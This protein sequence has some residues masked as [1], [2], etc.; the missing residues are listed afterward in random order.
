MKY[1][2]LTFLFILIIGCSSPVKIVKFQTT[3][4]TIREN[5]KTYLEWEVLNAD[6]III[7]QLGSDE[8][9]LEN[10][11]L[12]SKMIITPSFSTEYVLNAYKGDEYEKQKC[13]LDVISKPENIKTIRDTVV[14]VK[15]TISAD[16]SQNK[17]KYLNGLQTIENLNKKSKVQFEIFLVDRTNFPKEVKLYLTVKDENGNFIANMAPPFGSKNS[18]NKYFKNLQ[19]EIDGTPYNIEDY[20]IE[21]RHDTLSQKYSFSLVLDHSGSMGTNIDTL[22]KAVKLFVNKMEKQDKASI[23]KFDQFVVNSVSLTDDKSLLLDN[24]HYN[25]LQGFGGGTA[26]I[27][28]ADEGIRTLTDNKTTNIVIL[29][30]DGFENAYL[31]STII[32]KTGYAF[33]PNS[34][35]Y[36]AR[37]ANVKLVTVGYGNVDK[38]LLEKL[39]TLTDG[40]SYYAQNG[41]ELDQIFNELPRLFHNYYVLKFKPKKID[42]KHSFS[43]TVANPDGSEDKITKS[44]YV[45]KVDLKDLDFMARQC[46]AFF[47]LKSDEL[48]DIYRTY[49]E[50]FAKYLQMNTKSTLEIH[51]HTDLTGSKEQ[52]M[53]ISKRRCERVASEFKKNGVDKS[54]IK[55]NPH[56]MNEPVWFPELDVYQSEQNRR[57]EL[58]IKD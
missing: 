40:K 38:D 8:E 28:A 33:K 19:D 52:N 5:E 2:N 3:Y 11:P 7:K 6:S 24:Y 37:A 12:K 53:E 39:S 41:K 21:E 47:E 17:S 1:L 44:T 34:L 9:M 16:P 42:G 36:N 57:V 27:A 13:W 46:V 18:A 45:G 22:H 55:L 51:G 48:K 50:S 23:V 26:L 58:I 20:D 32:Q 30:T 49:I 56:G 15:P 54:R 25:G 35:I 43:M 14:I 4:T 10:A 31:Y 29:F